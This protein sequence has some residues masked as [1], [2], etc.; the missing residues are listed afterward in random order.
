MCAKVAL[1][2]VLSAITE[3]LMTD[4]NEDD[5]NTVVGVIEQSVLFFEDDTEQQYNLGTI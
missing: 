4:G 2:D 5:I 3:R 1:S